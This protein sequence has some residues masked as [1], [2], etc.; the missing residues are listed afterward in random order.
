MFPF[1]IPLIGAGIGAMANKKDPIKG[2]LLGGGLGMAGG[3]ALPGMIS[4]Q[5]AAPIVEAGMAA[6]ITQSGML[7]GQEA[8]LGLGSIGWNGATTGAGGMANTLSA[9]KGLLGVAN[10]SLDTAAK[11]K[12]LMPNN[13]QL[14]QAPAFASGGGNGSVG[15]VY[16]A[17]QNQR[18]AQ[19][20]ADNNL[21]ALRAKRIGLLG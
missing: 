18:L 17:L 12:T 3:A 19:R 2:A 7:A 8:G 11:V 14:P 6:P 9:N 16:Q 13:S 5:A 1:M 20:E 4:T 10:N 21:R 15:G